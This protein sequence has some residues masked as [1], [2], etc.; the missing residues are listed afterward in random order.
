MER[1]RSLLA[2]LSVAAVLV[3]AVLPATAT[4][5][6]T[7]SLPSPRTDAAAV[8]TGDRI[9]VFGG[10]GPGGDPIDEIVQYDPSDGQISVMT[11]TLP[12]PRS[13]LAAVWTG[14]AAYLFG[15]FDRNGDPLAEIVRYDPGNDRINVTDAVLPGARGGASAVW[16]GEAAYIFG[17]HTG[18]DAS[19]EI[20]RHE[21]G[22]GDPQA[23]ASLP[24]P[25]HRT[26]AVWADDRAYIFGGR[27]ST[28]PDSDA[29]R[30]FAPGGSATTL[31]GVDLPQAMDGPSA[32][33]DGEFA[34]V[35]GG[36]TDDI[37]LFDPEVPSA[38]VETTLP[39]ARTGTTSIWD[40]R[41]AYV[42]GGDDGEVLDDILR[43]DPP[44]RPP[45]ARFTLTTDELAVDV[46]ATSSSDIDGSVVSYRW[47]WGDGTNTSG[48][49][50][51]SH[52]Y[53][54]PGEYTIQLT[55]RD[56][57]G[58]SRT[59][60]R[61]V[62]LDTPNAVPV[63]QITTTI[64]DLTVRVDAEG[65]VDPDGDIRRYVW[66]WGD[67]AERVRGVQA[68]HT[69][70]SPGNYTI[71]LTVVDDRGGLAVA[72]ESVEVGWWIFPNQ[73]I[74]FVTLGGGAAT[75]VVVGIGL[76]WWRRRRMM[77]ALQEYHRQDQERR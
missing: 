34:Y 38:A 60:S 70:G 45:V 64:D 71:R 67:G 1:L 35:F 59:T 69:Y 37:V 47:E 27:S 19:S 54:S 31:A 65:S 43:Y 49:A 62:R 5:T 10:T 11:A 51:A 2:P 15:G 66:D 26:A 41:F 75:L 53:A 55:V 22:A 52:T 42:V 61:T 57:D 29:I 30:S 3:L 39:T 20:L 58:S 25:L 63:P 56:D 48:G 7:G 74:G 72:E 21:P 16:T 44:N 8:W 50:T 23:V 13:G 40:G 24:E 32:A 76:A 46:D 4:V 68:A 6:D 9:Y 73:L 33:W 12:T 28:G 17:G 77:R 18:Q 36:D 14:E